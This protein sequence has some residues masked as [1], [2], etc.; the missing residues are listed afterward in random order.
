MQKDTL[1]F[2]A[3]QFAKMHHLNKRT[4]H[5]YD[6][7]GLFSP[8]FKGENG[9][10]Y[11]TYHQSV[12]L[13]NILSL[14]DIGMSIEE[15]KDYFHSLSPSVFQEIAVQ[16]TQ[17]IDEQI[18]RLKLLKGLLQEKQKALRLCEQAYDGKIETVDLEEK[19]LLLSPLQDQG[20]MQKNMIQIMEHL[21]TAQEY[22]AYKVGCG[23]Y[24]SLE[25]VKN[26]DFEEY[27]GLF[28]PVRKAG[29][30]NHFVTLPTGVYL[31]GYCIGSW[32]KIPALYSK[33]LIWAKE[34]ELELMGN[35]YETGLNEFA[36]ADFEDYVTQIVIPYRTL[37]KES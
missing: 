22:N 7:I 8:A 28:T 24:I 5:Y 16:K 10:R 2:T 21:Y 34:H 18:K 6:E 13:E 25:K 14:R 19:Y 31:C 30:G 11:Y 9:Y 15:V 29:R 3:G 17:E 36:I 20:E 23:S 1:L 26:N 37:H 32:D 33:M 35:C 4:L 12:T 27:D